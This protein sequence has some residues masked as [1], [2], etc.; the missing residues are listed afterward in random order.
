VAYGSL[1]SRHQ[2]HEPDVQ[3]PGTSAF[4]R[5]R[6]A[7]LLNFRTGS[8]E[9]MSSSQPVLHEL[10]ETLEANPS[11]TIELIGHTDAQGSEESNQGLSERRARSVYAWLVDN[12][13][14][15]SRLRTSGRGELQ[16]IADNETVEG[17][18][19]NR[20]VEVRTVR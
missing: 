17:R 12:G 18:A 19:L 2:P 4:L 15:P 14:T 1:P 13:I 9:L 11:L 16:P 8:A 20:R 5:R 7:G 3:A 10:R 6:V